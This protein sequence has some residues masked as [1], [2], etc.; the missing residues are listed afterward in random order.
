MAKCPVCGKQVNDWHILTLGAKTSVPCPGCHSKL[1]IPVKVSGIKIFVSTGF[2]IGGFVG[3]LSM[4][5]G[6]PLVWIAIVLIWFLLLA[7]A[8]IRYTQ[9][10]KKD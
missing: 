7:L 2:M 9:L 10:V 3:G 1:K 5:S 8:D 4:V 6:H